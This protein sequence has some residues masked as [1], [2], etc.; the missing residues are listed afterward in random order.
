MID[1]APIGTRSLL[2]LTKLLPVD[3]LSE[4]I[5]AYLIER[6]RLVPNIN[7]LDDVLTHI[8]SQE[9]D[10]FSLRTHKTRPTGSTGQGKEKRQV[11]E[12]PSKKGIRN[13]GSVRRGSLVAVA[14]IVNIN[15]AGNEAIR[16]MAAG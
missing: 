4:K 1:E 3:T 8:L 6:M 11:M 9:A 14:L 2:H 7:S 10:K 15:T 16:V 13:A 5:K 12:T